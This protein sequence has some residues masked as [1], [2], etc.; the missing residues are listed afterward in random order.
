[1]F[2]QGGLQNDNFKKL[3]TCKLDLIEMQDVRWNRGS[4]EPAREYTAFY[5]KEVEN[6]ELCTRL[7]GQQTFYQQLR[8]LGFLMIGCHT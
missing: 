6:D 5:R 4:M 7:P 1:M 8:G 3:L 2:L